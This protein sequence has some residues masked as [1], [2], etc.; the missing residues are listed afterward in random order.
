MTVKNASLIHQLGSQILLLGFQNL[1]SGFALLTLVAIDA[2]VLGVRWTGRVWTLC[3]WLCS[4]FR[5]VAVDAHTLGVIFRF[6]VW[7]RGDSVLSNSILL[8]SELGIS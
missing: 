6:R 5:V 8:G 4:S 7:T 1:P 2:H 3:R